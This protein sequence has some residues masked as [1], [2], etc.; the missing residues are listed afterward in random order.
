V[1]LRAEDLAKSIGTR[2]LFAEVS[3]EVHPGD[4]LGV[5]GP[6]GAGKTTLLR[7]LAGDEPVD[8]GRVVQPRGVRIGRLRQ[9]VDPTLECSIREEAA[10]ALDPLDALELERRAIEEEIAA[11]GRRGEEPGPTLA[12]RYDALRA[13][14]ELAGGFAREAR[15]A[16]VLAGL[17]FDEAAADRPVRSLSG[18]WLMRV[19]LAKL[20][21]SEPDVLLLDEPTNHLD[22]PAIEWLEGFLA[23]WRGAVVAVSHDRR[24]LRRHVARIAELADGTLSHYTGNWDRYQEERAERR[25][26]IEAR[27]RHQDRRRAEIERFVERFRAKAS[28]AR[29][30]QSRVKALERLDDATARALPADPRGLRLRIPAPPRGG[31]P[32]VVLDG[33]AQGYGETLV[34]RDLE[35]TIR[36]G[37]RIALVGPNG[38]GK[39]TLLRIVAGVIPIQRGV[40][41]LGHD[42]RAA[43][44][45]Q[46]QLEALDPTRTV[47]GELERVAELGD[48]P[49]LRGHLG[50]LLFSG[51]D[52]E[53]P[54]GVLSGGEKARL[55]LAKLLL[56]PAQLLVLDEPTNHLDVA[57]CEVL[58]QALAAWGGTVLFVSHDR[59][60]VNAVATRVV[61]VRAGRLRTFAGNYDAYL[62]RVA[63]S[64]PGE[65]GAPDPLS[66]GGP[67]GGGRS[68]AAATRRRDK[69][70]RR[71]EARAARELARTED[72]ILER[73]RALEALAW[74]AADPAVHRDG[75][76][77]RALE[78]ER[79]ALREEIEALY[80][81]WEDHAAAVDASAEEAG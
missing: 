53:K 4:R 74:R 57:A 60:F 28:K 81:T 37:E 59:A 7:I 15:V 29:Q 65:G 9:E 44:H 31:D 69:E 13:R 75:E 1:L 39:S 32:V 34:Y 64:D 11:R 35:L 23:G 68:E 26:Q 71:A 40:R 61:E 48:I 43:F 66:A 77:M 33:V 76:R 19:E 78:A 20:L 8:A 72:A 51:D 79:A 70:R 18:G 63:A 73:E 24:F 2:R 22:L 36:R 21:L 5:V 54:V 45:A 16:R 62:E 38:A 56:R 3:L 55:A 49:R 30:V 67:A 25:A 10:R 42:V 47:L 46:H 6:N 27:R 12:T 17:G 52:V 41:R 58:E 50:A 80:R 14:F